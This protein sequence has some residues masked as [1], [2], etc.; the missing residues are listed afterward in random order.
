MTR[1]QLKKK[2]KDMEFVRSYQLPA[3]QHEKNVIYSIERLVAGLLN[4]FD[5]TTKRIDYDNEH[6]EFMNKTINLETGEI[7]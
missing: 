6:Y 7:K 4:Q 3:E 1:E 5:A 2:L